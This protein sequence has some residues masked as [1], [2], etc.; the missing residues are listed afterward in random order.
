MLRV[1][2]RLL[3]NVDWPLVATALFIVALS[4]LSMWSLSHGRGSA[5]LLWRQLV[6]VALGLLAL[7]VMASID[8]QNLVR[9]APVLYLGGLGLLATVFVLGRTVAGARRWIHI[10]PLTFQPSELFKLVFVLTLAWALTQ[11]RDETLSR[12]TLFLTL[13][14]LAVPFALVVRQPDLGTALVLV[15]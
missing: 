6:W 2:R 9:I 8:Y 13:G 1:D 15:P 4:V 11:R 3:Q 12:G 5:P 10:G 7:L 14:L